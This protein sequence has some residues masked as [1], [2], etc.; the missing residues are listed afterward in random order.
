MTG[1]QYETEKNDEVFTR[2]KLERIMPIK[3]E[4][5]LKKY[6]NDGIILSFSGG[7]AKDGLMNEVVGIPKLELVGRYLL[8]LR[9][10]K[11]TM[12][13]ISGWYQGAFQV[14]YSGVEKHYLLL[15]MNDDV[16][17]NAKDGDLAFKEIEKDL[18]QGDKTTEKKGGLKT[19]ADEKSLRKAETKKHFYRE[20][21]V[22][23]IAKQDHERAVKSAQERENSTIK[24]RKEYIKEILGN[25]PLYLDEF[26]TYIKKTDQKTQHTIPAALREFHIRPE[27]LPREI[28]EVKPPKST[29]RGKLN[30]E[31]KKI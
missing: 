29:Q 20:D 14:V 26:I 30:K 6:M 18:C 9:G 23:E 28:K 19:T 15:N 2:V 10:G 22:Q 16:L 11:W 27:L 5:H 21:N 7:L 8:F 12:N 24:N 17:L 4:H 31:E 13:P 1:I 25:N 3:G